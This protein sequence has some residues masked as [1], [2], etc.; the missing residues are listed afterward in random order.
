VSAIDRYLDALGAELRVRGAV[1]RRILRE[2]RDHLGDAA[3]A[4]GEEAAVRAFGPPAEIAAAFDAEVAARRGL[5][6]TFA[7]VAGVLATGGSTLVLIHASAAGMTA[8]TLWAIAFFVG[9]QLAG[10]AAGLALVQALAQRRS[11]M[12]PADVLL[13]SRRNGCA[14]VAAGV[15]MFSA[16]A[17]LPGQGSAVLL[18]AGPA[19]VCV[20]LVAVLRARSLARR[21]DGS[22]ALVARPPLEDLARLTRLPVPSLDPGPLLLLTTCLAAAAAFVR[23]H[24][25]HATAGQALVTAGIEAAAVVACFLVLGRGLGLRGGTLGAC[26]SSRWP[27]SSTTTT[28]RSS[29]SSA[30]SDSTSSR[31]RRR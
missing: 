4:R 9:A 26:S 22:H 27:S 23:D 3:V 1:R 20:A 31:T 24:G 29:S 17:A 15:T 10:V 30:S 21:L 6:S 16:G 13:L 14:L 5:R 25:E 8:P 19:L 28:G 18:L 7:T 12:A 11:A 2:C